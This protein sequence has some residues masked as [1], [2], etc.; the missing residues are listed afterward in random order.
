MAGSF[1]RTNNAVSVSEPPALTALALISR[2]STH[3][4]QTK[5]RKA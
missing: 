2:P 4:T 1:V 3:R 5:L